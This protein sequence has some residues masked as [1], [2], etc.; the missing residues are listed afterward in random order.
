[1][2][3]EFR[4]YLSVPYGWT[5]DRVYDYAQEKFREIAEDWD[6]AGAPVSWRMFDEE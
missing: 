2:S 4:L 3:L 6:N 1:M 5:E